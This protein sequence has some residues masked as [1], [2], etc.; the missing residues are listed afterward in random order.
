MVFVITIVCITSCEEIF[1]PDVNME[2]ISLLSPIDSTVS[3]DTIQTF[4]W[5]HTLQYA[6]YQ[7]QVVSPRFDSMIK[8]VADTI[9]SR[10]QIKL[11]LEKGRQY[12]WRVR[13]LTN[14]TA[15]PNSAVWNLWVQ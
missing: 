6:D 9:T 4:Y 5:Q 10:N 15:T 3:Q 13:G 12:Q 7:L 2:R 14:S 8:L 1:E 11:V